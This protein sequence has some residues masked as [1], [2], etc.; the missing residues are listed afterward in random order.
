MASEN[1]LTV[2]EKSAKSQR[3][4][5]FL[6]VVK[7]PDCTWMTAS[8]LVTGLYRLTKISQLKKKLC[9]RKPRGSMGYIFYK[10]S[11]RILANIYI[12]FFLKH[13]SGPES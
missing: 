10:I 11:L 1:F 3:S 2:R 9:I 12:Y 5:L 8:D 7:L 13:L 6:W 4:F